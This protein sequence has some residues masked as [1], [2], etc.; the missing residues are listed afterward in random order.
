MLALKSHNLAEV[1]QPE[2]RRLPSMPGKADHWIGGRVDMLDNVFLKDIIRHTKQLALLISLLLVQIIAIVAAQV[3]D[4]ANRLG[5]NL[6]FPG[7]FDH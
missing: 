1:F 5:E 3:A 4:G 6:K 2:E 7:R